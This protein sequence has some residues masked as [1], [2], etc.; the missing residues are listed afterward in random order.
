MI[1]LEVAEA[2]GARRD[3]DEETDRQH[4]LGFEGAGHEVLGFQNDRSRVDTRAGLGSGPRAQAMRA[5]CRGSRPVGG[6]RVR[7]VKYALAA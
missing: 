3:E 7:T 1:T 4:R 5:S 2:L 6:E